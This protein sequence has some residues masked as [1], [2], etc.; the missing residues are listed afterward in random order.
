MIRIISPQDPT[1]RCIERQARKLNRR[2]AGHSRV[3]IVMPN[4]TSKQK[5]H[6]L[7]K[8]WPDTDVIVFLGHGRSDALYGSRGR[9]FDLAGAE[10]GLDRES[11]DYYS[12][13]SFVDNTSYEL[14]AGKCV[15]CFACDTNSLAK[16]LIDAG[17]NVVVGFGKMPSSQIEFSE[18]WP[19]VKPVKDSMIAYINGALNVA[20]REAI[21]LVFKMDGSV[22]D[23]AV[24]F[25]MEM[26]KQI[27]RLLHSKA[28][29]RYDISTVLYNVANSVVVE[30]KHNIKFLA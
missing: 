18:D 23:I 15:V 11:D 14:F 21:R 25:K 28:K 16:K 22:D 19:E 7:I 3:Y 5:C 6:S 10:D 17:A 27:S 20:F 30:G 24:Y 9:Y 1:S 8:M 13:D 2:L 29:Y 4:D 12:D 26:R